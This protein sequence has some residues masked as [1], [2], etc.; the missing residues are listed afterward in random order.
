MSVETPGSTA[1]PKQKKGLP[2]WGWVLI[3]CGGLVVAG[4]ILFAALG[5]F[6]FKKGTELAKEATGVESFEE[7]GKALEDNPVKTAAE[8]AIRLNPELEIVES[9][10]EAGTLTFRNKKTGE[11]ATF[12]YKEIAEGKFSLSTDEGEYSV[13]ASEDEGGVVLR[14]PEGETRFGASASLDDVPGWVP[15]YPGASEVVSGYSSRTAEGSTG[16]VSSVTGDSA[17]EV[18]DHFE[19]WFEEQGWK[20]SSRSLTSSGD[21]SFGAIAGELEG[22][23]RTLNIGVVETADETRITVNYVES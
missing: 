3:G 21:G 22:E 2:V 14:G 13:S 18:L 8:M 23:G 16:M 4:F 15:G 17:Q 5:F 6:V 11:V 19:A 9:D 10:G 1:Q 20:V 12:G 7:L